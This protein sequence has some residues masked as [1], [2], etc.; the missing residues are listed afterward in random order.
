M[1][2]NFTVSTGD[3][4]HAI[5][6]IREVAQWCEKTGKN[7]WKLDELTEENLVKGLSPENF[8]IGMMNNEGVC[9]M[10]LQWNDT[11]FWPDV[12]KNESGFIHKL[13]VRREYAG[14]GFSNKMVEYARE[15]CKRRGVRYLRLDTG[16]S[17]SKLCIHYE[18][19][20]FK[21]VG[22]RVIKDKEYAL[23]EMRVNE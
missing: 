2:N 22:K 21:K 7:M 14:Q 20:G 5:G 16:W 3:V 9:S 1:E 11:L 8:C 17:R 12:E 13:C 23:Y 18:G 4:D 10:I 15:E 19:L 6:I